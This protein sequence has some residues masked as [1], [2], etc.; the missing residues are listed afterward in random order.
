[1]M[2]LERVECE[3]R[4]RS[5]SVRYPSGARLRLRGTFA[6]V[7]I[8]ADGGVCPVIDSGSEVV[9]LDPRAVV[10]ETSGRVVYHP[11][12]VARETLAP[13]VREWLDAHLAW[14]AAA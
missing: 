12:R 5:Y 6:V 10:R 3:S 11:A 9:V 2:S 1:M 4:S 8:G 13:W 14:E 7:C